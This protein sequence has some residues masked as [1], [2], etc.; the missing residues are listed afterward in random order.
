MIIKDV[1]PQWYWTRGLHD[2]EIVDVCEK[3]DRENVN[4]LI[5][6]DSRFA[7]FESTIESI[8]LV[9]YEC[10]CDLN[11][12]KDCIWIE[13]QLLLDDGGYTLNVTLQKGSEFF[14]VQITFEN[15]IVIG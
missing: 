8:E 15:A 2:A 1:I 14:D 3:Y 4:M 13:D 5:T 10:D 9:N 11:F 12:M 6:L 7:M